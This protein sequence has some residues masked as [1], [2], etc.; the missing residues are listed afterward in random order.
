MP[1]KYILTNLHHFE[2]FDCFLY[3]MMVDSAYL[4]KST[5]IT[6][7]S[8]SVQYFASMLQTYF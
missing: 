5:P 4:V 7:S 3:K 2:L 8:V 1:K 6:A